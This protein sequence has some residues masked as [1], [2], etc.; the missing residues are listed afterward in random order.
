MHR[1]Q[2]N[3]LREYSRAPADGRGG[4]DDGGNAGDK[5]D[6]FD[7]DAEAEHL[8]KMGG[9][10][11][12]G[13]TELDDDVVV[14]DEQDDPD[15]DAN[16][17][18]A[19]HLDDEDDDEDR[20]AKGDKKSAFQERIDR[21]TKEKNDERRAREVAEGRLAER[22][23][24]L[25]EARRVGAATTKTAIEAEIAGFEDELEKA[26]EE[27]D[28]KKQAKVTSQISAANVKLNSVASWLARNPEPTAEERAARQRQPQQD[29]P[30]EAPRDRSRYTTDA[31][32]EWY[33][34]NT[35]WMAD[36]AR[37][38]ERLAVGEVDREL[39]A[40]GFTDYNDP[41]RYRELDK[42]MRARFPALGVSRDPQNGNR[43][44]R[45]QGRQRVAGVS[46]DSG[47]DTPRNTQG[48]SDL[49]PDDKANM[50]RFKL[51]PGNDAHVKAYYR[52]HKASKARR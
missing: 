37:R 33:D 16:R 41:A 29:Q 42:R 11:D 15:P 36:T 32:K 12:D 5:S 31:A 21:L 13:G 49:S 7:H 6:M 30:R 38:E 1:F 2:Y 46:R 43:G 3:A 24:G 34:R 10:E 22:D 39:A 44:Q 52:E 35:R 19:A 14:V 27:G 51:D 20:P 18:D 28:S 25:D 48:R 23:E 9:D 8:D 40:E 26:I 45:Q 4:G 47:G 17:A 50:R